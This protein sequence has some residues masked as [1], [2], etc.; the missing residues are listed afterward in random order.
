MIRRQNWPKGS[1][2]SLAARFSCAKSEQGNV[3]KC[4]GSDGDLDLASLGGVPVVPDA[5]AGKL[6][7][8]SVPVQDLFHLR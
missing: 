6:L 4:S 2:S 8:Q 1:V 3:L 5:F 7:E